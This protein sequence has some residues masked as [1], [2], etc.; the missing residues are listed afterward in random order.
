MY[1]Y[2]TANNAP[3]PHVR[4]VYRHYPG[5][6]VAEDTVAIFFPNQDAPLD[7]CE[8]QAQLYARILNAIAKLAL[9]DD[10]T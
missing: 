6:G 3:K 2:I 10:P 4:V 8:L 1:D 9:T 7:F 5:D